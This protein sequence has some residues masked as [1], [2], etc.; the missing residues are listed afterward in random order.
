L[1]QSILP[2][3]AFVRIFHAGEDFSG[4]DFYSAYASKCEEIDE[5][6]KSEYTQLVDTF[7]INGLDL[8][9]KVVLDISGGPGYVGK[10][11]SEICKRMI[12]TEYSGV[13]AKAMSDVLGI[14]AIKFDYNNDRLE[15]VVDTKFDVVL[16]RSSIIFCE[17]LEDLIVSVRNVLNPNGHILVETILPS[18]GEVFWWQQMEFKFKFIY[19]Q[20][21]IEK[22]FY[23]HG[24]SLLY[25][26]RD[27]EDYFSVMK[28]Q[29]QGLAKKLFTFAFE[30]PLVLAYYWLVRKSRVAIET[31]LQHSMLAQIWEMSDS[32][33][34]FQAKP[35]S[36]YIIGAENHSIHFGMRYN[37]YLRRQ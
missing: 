19:S 5:R 33:T 30:Y 1:L 15:D 12:V 7:E 11:L 16:L 22:L 10:K 17:H 3:R 32:P 37:N 9:D 35:Y 29:R 21:T 24:F 23:K 20:E 25:G 36:N 8:K 6:G 31:R 4:S 13:A 28:R 18:L 26:Q 27:Y 34:K 14:Q 2:E